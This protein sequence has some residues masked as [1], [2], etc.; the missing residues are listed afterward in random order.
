[1]KKYIA[2]KKK[3]ERTVQKTWQ[4]IFALCSFEPHYQM[5]FYPVSKLKNS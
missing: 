2:T 5:V 3:I 1:M 4:K